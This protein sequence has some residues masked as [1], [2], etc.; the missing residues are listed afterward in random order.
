MT[1]PTN[2]PT[3]ADTIDYLDELFE[4]DTQS[5]EVRAS[6]WRQVRAEIDRLRGKCLVVGCQ[7]PPLH[8]AFCEQHNTSD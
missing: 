7:N 4:G 3:V 2:L 1:F 6:E 5:V 8:A